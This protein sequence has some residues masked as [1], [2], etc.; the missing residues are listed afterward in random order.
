MNKQKDRADSA[1]DAEVREGPGETEQDGE[2]TEVSHPG[3]VL[4]G[5][6]REDDG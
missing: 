5:W 2:H 4:P 6:E 1:G 3:L